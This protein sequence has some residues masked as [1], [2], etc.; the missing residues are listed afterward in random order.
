MKNVTEHI[1]GDRVHFYPLGLYGSDQDL[2]KIG[3][4]HTLDSLVR[5]AGDHNVSRRHQFKLTQ[6]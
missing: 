4:V 2:P 3:K 1:R 5:M 6:H